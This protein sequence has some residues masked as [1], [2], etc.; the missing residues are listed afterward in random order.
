M[1]DQE[2]VIT[3]L[4]SDTVKAALKGA[5]IN[6]VTLVAVATGKVFDIQQIQMAVDL[7]IPAL[8]NIVSL[9]YY[10]KAYKGRV[11]AT[12]AIATKPKE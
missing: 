1:L 3:R 7:G 10:Y 5:I 2:D 11:N 8:V 4:Q 12:Q 6:V 9:Y